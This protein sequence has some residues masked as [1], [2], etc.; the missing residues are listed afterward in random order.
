MKTLLVSG[1]KFGNKGGGAADGSR[2][3]N[4]MNESPFA[5]ILARAVGNEGENQSDDKSEKKNGEE[6]FEV[7]AQGSDAVVPK[8]GD[9]GRDR[10]NSLTG[11]DNA[12]QSEILFS[13]DGLNEQENG[14]DGG[15]GSG[16]MNVLG[17]S[18]KVMEV[19]VPKPPESTSKKAK[20]GKTKYEMKRMALFEERK[21]RVVYI[22]LWHH[23][24]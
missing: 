6:E 11:Q 17:A 22:T 18:P 7:D 9:A 14:S 23:R 10:G 16:S 4:S 19:G 12:N 24:Q 15:N 5:K 13:V 8:D 3:R 20:R 2:R 1:M 21:Y